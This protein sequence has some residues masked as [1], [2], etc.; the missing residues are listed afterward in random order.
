MEGGWEG[1]A[2]ENLTVEAGKNAL[3]CFKKASQASVLALVSVCSRAPDA[4]G[5]YKPFLSFPR[6]K[7]KCHYL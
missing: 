3:E 1:F 6:M 2:G 5:Q 4:L 7:K